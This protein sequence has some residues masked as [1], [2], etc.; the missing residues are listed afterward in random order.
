MN[1]KIK[2][3]IYLLFAFVF[4]LSITAKVRANCIECG[5]FMT[6][7]AYCS[8][9]QTLCT[10]PQP[11]LHSYTGGQY[12][13]RGITCVLDNTYPAS[14]VNRIEPAPTQWTDSNYYVNTQTITFSWLGN[15]EAGGSGLKN[16]DAQHCVGD[17]VSGP[18]SS[19][20]SAT[21]STSASIGVTNGNKYCFRSL[22]RDNANNLESKSTSDKCV[23]VDTN[24][25][26]ITSGPTI[27]ST[28][29]TG[30]KIMWWTSKTTKDTLYYGTS[31]SALTNTA[32]GGT[33]TTHSVT[34]SGLS[35]GTTYYYKAT[36]SYRNGASVS[37]EVKSFRTQ[38]NPPSI[39]GAISYTG[40]C[41]SGS[42]ITLSCTAVDS[43]G[44]IKN[45]QVWA[46]Q[47]DKS[48]C[49]ETRRWVTNSGKIY[50][51]G[52]SMTTSGSN[53]YTKT[54]TIDQPSGTSIAATC[55]A[56]DNSDAKSS[57][58]GVDK[59]PLCEVSD[60]GVCQ[61]TPTF[62]PIQATPNPAKAGDTITFGFTSDRD[63]SSAPIVKISKGLSNPTQYDVSSLTQTGRG[64]VYSFDIPREIEDGEYTIN[65]Q[66]ADT[67]G[68]A[69]STNIIFTIGSASPP[70]GPPAGKVVVN[71]DG[72]WGEWSEWEICSKT[73][74]TGQ[75]KH[76]RICNYPD[77]NNKG[78]PCSGPT[79]EFQD[80]NTFPCP[81]SGYSIFIKLDND[82][83]EGYRHLEGFR[84]DNTKNDQLCGIKLEEVDTAAFFG[85]EDG[86]AF[87]KGN[88]IIKKNGK[89]ILDSFGCADT[90][91][92]RTAIGNCPSISCSGQGKS[93]DIPC[94][95]F[96][97]TGIA[98]CGGSNEYGEGCGLSNR[99]NSKYQ[100]IYDILCGYDEGGNGK[101]YLCN[102]DNT[103]VTV[104]DKTYKCL[105]GEWVLQNDCDVNPNQPK[106]DPDVS[107][108]LCKSP[109]DFEQGKGCCGDDNDDK[110]KIGS[111]SALCYIKG[112]VHQWISPTDATNIGKV[113]SINGKLYLYYANIG[114]V[115]CDGASF[116]KASD[117]TDT[118]NIKLSIN[119]KDYLCAA[120]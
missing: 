74:G 70:I 100:P 18:W 35:P 112:G 27:L 3:M 32:D 96:K 57:W 84:F 95:S 83:Q 24:T 26:S 89:S 21:T 120:K 48:R 98:K 1:K 73:C 64:Y 72:I 22:A 39:T 66:G 105:G 6:L 33:D 40:E 116:R 34:L 29:L 92:C 15:D 107:Q 68:C 65:I 75:Q 37:S 42:T 99:A 10:G 17:C 71:T 13:C 20:I 45:V 11:R 117:N 31:S 77:N 30:A 56:T 118:G 25:I 44:T 110:G 108:E 12:F 80:C 53:T 52:E 85:N 93:C 51:N 102:I 115:Y 86:T 94:T 47:C 61:S 58:T 81:A 101:W 62:S 2:L 113:F 106:C 55:Q 5:Q 109:N 41:R 9:S 111:G 23:V 103:Q 82:I 59:Y 36:S 14:S 104:V 43:D 91:N 76:T 54:L 88:S 90:G 28:S 119:N 87:V 69:G 8:T 50:F 60:V 67:N 49:T 46:G 4:L 38:Q 7:P 63:L 97:E 19:T 114:W 16:Y 78:T 79:E